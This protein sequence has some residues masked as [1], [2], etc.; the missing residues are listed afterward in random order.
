[1]AKS[2]AP[3]SSQLVDRLAAPFA[4]FFA[5]EAASTLLLL[6]AAIAAL[7]WANSPWRE[8]YAAFWHLPLGVSL[9]GRE[10]SLSLEQ[11]VNDGLMVLFFFLVGMEIKH[12]LVDGELSSRERAMLP[13]FGAIGGMLVPVALYA[14]LHA[15]GPASAGWGVP[16]A[17]DIAFAVAAL[18]VFGKRVASGLKVFLLALAIVDDLGAVSVIAVFYSHGISLV[19]LACAGGGLALAFGLRRAGV[20]S[21]AVYA[22]VGIGVW[23]ATLQSGVHATFAGVLLGLCAPSRMIDPETGAEYS[24]IAQLTHALHP[25]SAFGVLPIFALASAGVAL[26][27]RVLADPLASRVTLGVALGLLL[28][29]P[30]GIALFA[31]LGVKARLAVLP[32]GVGWG[33]VFGAGVLGGIGFTMALF[34]TTLAFDAPAFVAASKVGVLGASVAATGLGMACLSRAL[35]RGA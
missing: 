30:L 10:L 18:A 15:G 7:V 31:W 33:A 26:D 4:K 27:A 1:M 17:T 6:L 32:P 5:I 2:P 13:L 19:A 22:F 24:P 29:K 11:W 8:S 16:M 21:Y 35:P 12:E 20:R 9:A 23:F 25:W 34:I 28:G 3:H 14:S